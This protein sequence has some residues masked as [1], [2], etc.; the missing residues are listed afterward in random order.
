MPATDILSFDCPGC[1]K[2]LK[3]KPSHAGRTT[4]CPKCGESLTV[5]TAG[6]AAD[7]LQEAFTQEPA[8]DA[9]AGF[10]PPA[11]EVEEFPPMIRTGPVVRDEPEDEPTDE[12]AEAAPAIERPASPRSRGGRRRGRSADDGEARTKTLPLAIGGGAV[13]ALGLGLAA[14][15]FWPGD[16]TATADAGLLTPIAE[17]SATEGETLEVVLVPADRLGSMAETHALTLTQAPDGARIGRDGRTFT[18][19]PGEADGPG[20][21]SVTA[22]LTHR[23]TGE[24]AETV[25]FDIQVAEEDLS[26]WIAPLA[27]VTV[28]PGESLTLKVSAEDPD[29]PANALAFELE[30]DVPAGVSVDGEGVIT[31]APPADAPQVDSA[32]GVKVVE[33]R[34]DGTAGASSVAPVRLSV[35][36]KNA[37]GRKPASAEPEPAVAMAEPAAPDTPVPA[38]DEPAMAESAVAD[39]AMTTPDAATAAEGTTV[40]MTDDPA[41]AESM[42]EPMPAP[43]EEPAPAESSEGGVSASVTAML[44]NEAAVPLN[45]NAAAYEENF[46][47]PLVA[48]YGGPDERRRPLLSPKEYGTLR[49]LFA[50]EFARAHEDQIRA[51]FGEKADEI[52]AWLKERPEVRETLFNAFKPSDDVAAGMTV[53]RQLYDEFGDGLDKY[54]GLATAAAVVWDDPERGPYNYEFH[55]KRAKATLPASELPAA[56]E[57]VRYFLDREAAM[58]GRAE[59]LPWELLVLTVDHETPIDERDWALTMYGN[60]R[61]QFGKCYSQVPY[62]TNMIKTDERETELDGLPYT[63]PT[64]LEK[65]GVC[66]HQADYAARVGKSLGVPAMYV[67]GDGKFGGA[68][69]AWVMWVDVTGV[70]DSALKFTLESHGRYQDDNYYVGYLNEPQTGE[71][72]TDRDLMRRLHSVATDRNASRHADLLMRAYPIVAQRAGEGG[73][74]LSMDARLDYLDA[75]N[76]I[77]TWNGAAW[78]ERARLGTENAGNLSK[79]Q[80]RRYKQDL[81]RLF[82]D[83]A[84]FPDFTQ[85]VFAGISVYETDE[86]KRL[87]LTRQL[88]DAY[89]AAGRPDLSF[90]TLPAYVDSLIAQNRTAEG[91]GLIT[92]ALMKYADE[93][94]YTPAALDRLDELGAESPQELIEFYKGFVMAIPP[95]RGN[96]PSEYAVAMHKRII[97]KAQA[98]NMPDVAEYFTE[99]MRAIGSG[100][101]KTKNGQR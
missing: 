2:T 77:D 3:A 47:A 48:M 70:T 61:N 10:E 21:A 45:E 71:E 94:R 24:A 26:P 50:E 25:A 83:F 18:W 11:E 12:A 57:N 16:E 93:G 40:A 88:L 58:Q 90:E 60:V 52:M 27:A 38:A 81:K 42:P 63:L 30:G 4:A 64:I 84:P 44:G 62:D 14:W 23:A 43:T 35:M 41:P 68:G 87:E 72:T 29:Q 98:A 54:G 6:G 74:E 75:V 67:R 78:R 8:A 92:D 101:L 9:A 80:T 19:T 91:V 53:F 55:A 28:G 66:A 86:E 46:V 76:Q 100:K 13:A 7:D 39:A 17:Q 85:E 99:R 31:F 32:F 15:A 51:G 1:G 37:P 22:A 59:R 34:A 56:V 33:Q 73:E 69:H 82:R 36:S 79:D 96:S 49:A 89:A 20:V 97:E 95:T 65:G 5:P